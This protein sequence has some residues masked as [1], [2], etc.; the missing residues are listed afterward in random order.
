MYLDRTYRPKRRRGAWPWWPFI[1]FALLAIVLYEQQ[2]A[3]LV[4]RTP[5]PTPTPIFSASKYLNDAAIALGINDFDAVIEAYTGLAETRPDEPTAHIKLS[6][7]GLMNQDVEGAFAHARR[8]I[9]VA[10]DDPDALAALA[11][12]YDWDGN[13]DSALQ[14]AL[15]GFDID[16]LNPNVLAVL[17]EIY[18]DNLNF[19]TAQ[20]YLDAAYELAPR[21]PLVLRNKGWLEESQSNYEDALTWYE[22]ALKEAPYRYDIHIE[23]GR[24]YGAGLNNYEEAVKSYQSAVDIYRTA[25]TLDALGYAQF[26]SGDPLIAIRTLDDAIEMDPNYALA[27][28]HRGLVYYARLNY[29]DAAPDLEKGV[30]LLGDSARVEHLYSLGLAYVYQEEQDCEK[31]IL[32]LRKAV[33][34]DENSSPALSG[35]YECNAQ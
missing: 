13:Y 29:E 26:L 35:L 31:A 2:P 20:E 16:P 28:I 14:L 9:E 30:T 8:A 15:D 11:R 17:G 32:W 24:Q 7:I 33:E 5:P 1:L 19:V 4:D 23:R 21:N 12:A 22:A 34:I 18:T 25:L 6:E 3:W 10:P 27:Y